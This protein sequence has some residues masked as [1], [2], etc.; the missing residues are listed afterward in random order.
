VAAEGFSLPAPYAGA[1][2]PYAPDPTQPP[3]A[4]W[5]KRWL[6]FT[7]NFAETI[8]F[9][10]AHGP[11]RGLRSDLTVTAKYLRTGQWHGA[12]DRTFAALA[13]AGAGP[14]DLV[15]NIGANNGCTALPLIRHGFAKRVI[16]IEP[17][18]T[19]VAL[20]ARNIA[21]N[22]LTP[23]VSMAPIALGAIDGEMILETSP[24]NKGDHRLAREDVT[25]PTGWRATRV[26]VRRLDDA[27]ASL[28]ETLQPSQ[29]LTWMDVQGAEPLVVAGGS[30]FFTRFPYVI[31]E[32]NPRA[33]RRLGATRDEVARAYGAIWNRFS[34]CG[35][36]G[37]WRT[38]G[39][40][41]LAALWDE[42]GEAGAETDLLMWR[43]P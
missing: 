22:E 26:P 10:S 29:V 18:P 30:T 23:H 5:V 38:R 11:M 28:L 6:K 35:A 20:C 41:E 1:T 32:F 14:I 25:T 2:I 16:A 43:T 31:A 24:T 42:L 37:V 7:R 33:M 8:A 36:D 39:V 4:R 15:I 12:L 34:V 19:N 27:A 21:D 13:D 40:A 3:R 17:D 9:R